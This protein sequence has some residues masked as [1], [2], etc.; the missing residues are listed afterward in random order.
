M[1]DALGSDVRRIYLVNGDPF[2]LSTYRLLKIAD[3][4]HVLF[5]NIETLACYASINELRDRSDYALQ[6]LRATG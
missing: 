4:V 1:H 6:E 5:P 2:A 3:I